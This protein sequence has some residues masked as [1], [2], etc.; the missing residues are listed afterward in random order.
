MYMNAHDKIIAKWHLIIE[1]SQFLN[2]AASNE[3]WSNFLS[4]SDVRAREVGQFFT[5]VRHQSTNYSQL[6]KEL[7][8][9]LA[10]NDEKIAAI[11]K[12]KR[13]SHSL[14]LAHIQS[15]KTVQSVYQTQQGF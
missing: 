7:Q 5:L 6:T 14:N 1:I 2:E 10:V 9:F 15:L 3:H 13:I 8:Q 11:L 12:G 4:L